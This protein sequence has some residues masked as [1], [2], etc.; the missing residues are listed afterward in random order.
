MVTF[1]KSRLPALKHTSR[2]TRGPKS[3]TSNHRGAPSLRISSSGALQPAEVT[4]TQ[5]IVDASDVDETFVESDVLIESDVHEFTEHEL[6]CKSSVTGWKELRESILAV[7]T[8][9][10]ALE[11]R[12]LCSICSQMA[13][14]R[15]QRCG[16][17]TF[18]C[19]QCFHKAHS[20]VNIF[21]IA[22]KWEVRK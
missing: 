13:C 18:F 20:D 14:L 22:E 16:P 6:H 4:S 1:R 10:A 3:V 5:A 21:H 8:E 2:P 17:M 19:S 9:S 15:C 7:V 11:E 12:Q